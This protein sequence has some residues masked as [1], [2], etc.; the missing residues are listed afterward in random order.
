MN[1]EFTEKQVFDKF[2]SELSQETKKAISIEPSFIYKGKRIILDFIG[3][4]DKIF[5]EKIFKEIEDNKNA[6]INFDK[7][8]DEAIK[9]YSTAQEIEKIQAKKYIN[10]KEFAEI[11]SVSAESQKNYRSRIYDPLPFHQKV[12]RGK[13]VYSTEKVEIWLGNQ[14]K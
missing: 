13:V 8:K 3:K 10:V 11:Y 2:I 5:L 14:H 9:E 6:N 4:S 7:L 1:R 12:R